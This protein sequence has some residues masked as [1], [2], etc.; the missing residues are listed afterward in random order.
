MKKALCFYL[1]TVLSSLGALAQPV[2]ISVQGNHFVTADGKTIV[3]AGWT[4][5][6]QTSCNA[7]ASGTNI[8]SRWSSHGARTS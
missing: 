4:Q 3:F 5:A 7:T 8:I 6:T 1:T 2:H